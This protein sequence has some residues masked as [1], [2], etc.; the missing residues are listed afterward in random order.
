VII[1]LAGN[2]CACFV[3]PLFKLMKRFIHDKIFGL[4]WMIVA[5]TLLFG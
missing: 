3:K 4:V 5:F 2:D 1:N